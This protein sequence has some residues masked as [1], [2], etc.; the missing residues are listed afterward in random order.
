MV[1]D[2]IWFFTSWLFRHLVLPPLMQRQVPP[3][4]QVQA[5]HMQRQVRLQPLVC[6]LQEDMQLRAPTPLQVPSL[7]RAVMQ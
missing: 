2:I 4:L 6:S 1:D 7:A 3:L 5:L